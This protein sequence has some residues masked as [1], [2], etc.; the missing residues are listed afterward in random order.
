[1]ALYD[2]VVAAMPPKINRAKI[3]A[4]LQLMC[5][6]PGTPGQDG[7][8]GLS[9]Y[10][11]AVVEG[12]VGDEAAWL[13]SLVGPEGQQ[14]EQGIQGDPGAQ[15]NPGTNGT[16]G[17]D[18]ADGVGVP[19]GGTTDQVLAKASNTDFDTEWVT[20]SA[21]GGDPLDAWPVG[22]VF[23]GVVSTSPATL[24]GGGTWARVAEGR[25]LISQS[26][27]PDFDTARETGGTKTVT[28]TAAQSGLPAHSHDLL[29]FPTATGGSSGFTVDT[30]MSGTPTAVTQDTN[31]V[32]GGAQN[33]AQAHSV[34]NPY[35]VVYMWE[36][37]A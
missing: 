10:E 16:N 15:G 26:T 5:E 29:R 27:D 20:P 28:L 18:G 12:F 3:L 35:F 7:A 4:G 24:L 13:A 23:I 30:S 34:M 11:V 22:S 36:R 33:A 32:V 2:D 9:A 21:G 6:A 8:D 25:M 14:G 17:T 31:G 37:T 19:A 1:M